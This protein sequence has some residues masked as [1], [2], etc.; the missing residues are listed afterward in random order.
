MRLFTLEE[1]NALLPEVRRL[2]RQIDEATAILQRLLPEVKRASE[3]AADGGG[4]TVYG[5]Q[6][7]NALTRFLASIQEI[8]S[9][10][11]EIKDFERGLCDFPHLREG[12]T[13]YLCWQRGEESI[14]WWHDIDAGFAG[15]QPL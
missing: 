14:E 3:H 6:Y 7:A 13:V 5:A 10:G 15:R 11:I 12:K 2:F 1:A 8:L 4:G 9:Y